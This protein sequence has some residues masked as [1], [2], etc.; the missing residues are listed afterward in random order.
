MVSLVSV[1]SRKSAAHK[2]LAHINMH[3]PFKTVFTANSNQPFYLSSHASPSSCCVMLL[4]SCHPF[5]LMA[6]LYSLYSLSGYISGVF[7]ENHLALS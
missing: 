1:F 5:Y 6:P 4:I 2:T 3:T 7:R